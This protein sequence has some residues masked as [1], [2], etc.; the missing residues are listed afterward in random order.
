MGFVKVLKNKAYSKRYQTKFRRRRQGKTDYYAR[1]R[2][3]V[4]D[5]DKYEAKKYRFCVRRTN[6]RIIC[7][8][9]Y[10]TI[11]GDRCMAAADSFELK[12][13]GLNAGLTN[14]SAAYCTG[15]LC[16]RRLLSSVSL[17]D[18][19]KG[20]A[21]ADGEY[22]SVADLD[23]PL[24][25][26]PFKALLDVGLIRT[27]TGNRVFGAM[28]GAC[29][30]GL[31][32]PHN[33]KR[34]PGFKIEKG[35][36]QKDK[37]GKVIDTEKSKHV[38]DAKVHREHILG[39]HVQAYYDL[40]KKENSGAFKKQFSNW[41]KALTASKAKS[42]EELYKKV[43]TEIRKKP[44]NVKVAR[45]HKPVRNTVQKAPALIQSNYAGK[46][47]LRQLRDNLENRKTR[48][49]GRIQKAMADMA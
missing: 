23:Q 41:E 21:A 28:K 3:V 30:G 24:D 35:E 31:H 27:T 10:A 15:L 46:K 47:W 4:Q 6:K 1:K 29:D 17:A 8:V 16:A 7:Q 44:E 39:G 49:A 26:R 38:Y 48:V 42:F 37:R 14:Y 13:Y 34:F 22:Y 40:L 25:R 32:I 45:K 11:K 19:Y 33:T 43:H 2:L 20:V 12:K 36:I 18:M 5:K 9:I